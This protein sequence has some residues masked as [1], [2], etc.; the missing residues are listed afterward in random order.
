MTS[1]VCVGEH[2]ELASLL[3]RHGSC[4]VNVQESQTGR[5]PLHWAVELGNGDLVRM[6]IQR[7]ADLNVADKDWYTPFLL[8]LD[9]G[10]KDFVTYMLATNR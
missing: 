2:V 8:A 4:D 3:A 9:R 5:T 1:R 7:G 10:H 6:L